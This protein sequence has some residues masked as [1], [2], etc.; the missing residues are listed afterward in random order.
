MASTAVFDPWAFESEYMALRR[1][2]VETNFTAHPEALVSTVYHALANRRRNQQTQ[3]GTVGFGIGETKFYEGAYDEILHSGDSFGTHDCPSDIHP[4]VVPL[5]VKHL[6]DIHR[7]AYLLQGLADFYRPLIGDTGYDPEVVAMTYN[8]TYRK[9]SVNDI[10]R[11]IMYGQSVF[12]SSQGVLLDEKWGF[13]PH[14]TW[15]DLTTEPVKKMLAGA[16]LHTIGVTRTYH[17]R[18]GAGPFLGENE[19]ITLKHVEPDNKS[20]GIQGG[21]RV[22]PLVLPLLSYGINVVKPQ[23]LSVTHLDKNYGVWPSKVSSLPTDAIEQAFDIP[24]SAFG[25][26]PGVENG[27]FDM[28]H[29]TA[30]YPPW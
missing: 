1:F 28:E 24:V 14:T 19:S 22:G 9:I 3:H 6:G 10:D 4:D 17:T 15:S 5:R 25:S 7:T 8:D 27:G 11:E 16:D 2:G 29:L 23:T 20:D 18:H 30:N 26:G 13:H 21:F 12:E